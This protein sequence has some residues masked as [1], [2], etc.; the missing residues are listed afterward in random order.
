MLAPSPSDAGTINADCSIVT[1]S[2]YLCHMAP[3]RERKSVRNVHTSSPTGLSRRCSIGSDS[4]LCHLLPPLA[5]DS[6]S[7]LLLTPVLCPTIRPITMVHLS[8]GPPFWEA[9]DCRAKQSIVI[10]SRNLIQKCEIVRDLVLSRHISHVKLVKPIIGDTSEIS[11]RERFIHFKLVKRASGDISDMS[12][13]SRLR[14]V[15]LVNPAS[16]DISD[17]SLP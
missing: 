6:K 10:F 2:N 16:G 9:P 7:S 4:Y 3:P 8:D 14:R 17:I 15:N 13:V 12:L 11:L 1:A 5:S